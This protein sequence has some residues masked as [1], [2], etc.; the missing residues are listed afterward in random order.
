MKWKTAIILN[1]LLL[2]G[3]SV[4]E[5]EARTYTR[6]CNAAYRVVNADR[7][8]DPVNVWIFTAR[9]SMDQYRPNTIRVVAHDR[10][11]ACLRAGWDNLHDDEAP[12]QCAEASGVYSYPD[13]ILA[14]A[15]GREACAAW[16][17]AP[18]MSVRVWVY[19]NIWGNRGCGG[20]T[21]RSRSSR[22][23]LSAWPEEITCR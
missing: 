20:T 2:G 10:A 19:A 6:S 23:L 12:S 5:A 9:Y 4:S 14:Y 22:V 15:I 8:Q 16:G 7:A 13:G 11:M 17:L 1:I 21:T 3:L 18:G